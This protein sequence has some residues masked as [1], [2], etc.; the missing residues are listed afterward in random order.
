MKYLLL[1]LHKDRQHIKWPKVCGLL[2]ISVTEVR[3]V[4]TRGSH[5]EPEGSSDSWWW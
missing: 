3:G 2:K 4:A 1:L 5:E